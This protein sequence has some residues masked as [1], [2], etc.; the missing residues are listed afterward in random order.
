VRTVL[1]I[2]VLLSLAAAAYGV[3]SVATDAFAAHPWFAWTLVAYGLLAALLSLGGMTPSGGALLWRRRLG[4]AL[5]VV[6]VWRGGPVEGHVLQAL[7]VLWTGVV[8]VAALGA[9]ARMARGAP[10]P[11]AHT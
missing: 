6:A 3:W 9:S 8:W 1:W 11:F 2:D 10:N 5:V 4:L 7:I